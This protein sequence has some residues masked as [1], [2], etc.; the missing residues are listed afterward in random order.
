MPDSEIFTCAATGEECKN[1]RMYCSNRSYLGEEKTDMPSYDELLK[2]AKAMH[3]W[4]FLNSADEQEAYDK[5]GLSDEMN[6]LLGYGG[7][8]VVELSEEDER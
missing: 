1:R 6:A 3:T 5:C 7:K 2:A 4:I 8:L